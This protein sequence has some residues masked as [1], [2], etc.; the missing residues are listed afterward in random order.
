MVTFTDLSENFPTSWEWNF[1]DR[2]T[3][4]EQNP[5]HTYEK[6]GTYTVILTVTNDLGSDTLKKA[7][8]IT[9]LVSTTAGPTADFTADVTEGTAPLT[10]QFTDQSTGDPTSWSWDFG[11]GGSSTAQ[12]PLH[13]YATAGTY[14]VSLT[15]T[16]EAGTDTLSI[17]DYITVTGSAVGPTA[18][19]TSD[20][21]SGDAPLTVQ[22]T[23]RST[24]EPISWVWDF[25][26]RSTSTEQNP[27]H[28]YVKKGSYTVSLTVSD[29]TGSD[30]L[31]VRKY[32]VVT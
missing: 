5:V 22:F 8:Y 14:T 25:G 17:G 4:T 28:T 2:S 19:F 15:V 11:D 7:K 13:E 18:D 27:Q 16:S 3:S 31:K 10:V 1:G 23:D 12:N 9:V 26:D 29:D 30:T 32:I 21:T 24:G 6:K 20:V